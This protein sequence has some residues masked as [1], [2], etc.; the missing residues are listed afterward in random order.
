[1]E[2]KI[3]AP[4]RLGV[5]SC[6]LGEE[7]RYDGQHKKDRYIVD[8]LGRYMEFVSV[9]PEVECGFSVPREAF[10]L[11]GDL[12][13][14]RMV[15]Q[16]TGKDVTEAMERWSRDKV[17]ELAE[18]DLC[19]FIFKAKSPS[20][21][22]ERV[23]VYNAKGNPVSKGVGIFARIFMERFPLLPVEEEGR[24]HD[25][26]LREKFIE[27]VFT[28][29]RWRDTLAERASVKRLVDFH[30]RHKLLVM[31]HSPK[32]YREMGRLV[33][34]TG[35]QRPRSLYTAYE[36]SL[37][38]AL[39]VPATKGKHANVLQ[40]MM[41]YFKRVLEPA[42]KQELVGLIDLYRQEVVPL[43]VPLTLINHYVR[44]YDQEYLRLQVYLNPHPIELKLRNHV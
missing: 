6:L 26:G 34:N 31:A 27:A 23:K 43:I 33:A 21:G 12:E 15:T 9:C 2:E 10:R 14:P 36:E 42:E 18:L 28:L 35:G 24:L 39:R 16:K 3:T 20:N 38:A 11:V 13:R 30:S 17:R 7:T 4:L 40:H 41:G 32:H 44:K 37:L 1:M 19:G 25:D 8:T 29:K 22:M 5:N